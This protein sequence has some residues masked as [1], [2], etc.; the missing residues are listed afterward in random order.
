MTAGRYTVEQS[1]IFAEKDGYRPIELDVHRIDGA[2]T[3]QPLMLYVH[4]GG[5]RVS[6]RQRAPRETRG[7]EPSFF[8]R[9]A[10]AGFVVAANDYRFSA[11]ALYP[12]AIEDTVDALG[13]MRANADRFGID[14]A[15]V[16]VFGQSAG[17]YLAAAVGLD[18]SIDPVRGVVCWYPL[19]DFSWLDPNDAAAATYPAQFL[20]APLDEVPE[21][22]A[23]SAVTRL[24]HAGA[25]PFLLHHGTADT[26]A[27]YNQSVAL[28]DALEAA[29]ARVELDTVDGAEHFFEGA[30]TERVEQI[31][32]RTVEFA[33]SCVA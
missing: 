8:E 5:W 21:L 18:R 10:A 23:A 9:L 2:T 15:R 24:A 20:G 7:W 22:V 26:M 31:F 17:G 25:P 11:E 32:E 13:F 16:V 33:R 6:S 3:P 28:R 14:P 27:P 30:G 4:G 19:T 29:G 12:A 1:V